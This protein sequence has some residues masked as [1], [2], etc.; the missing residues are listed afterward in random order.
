[1]RVEIVTSQMEGDAT[2]LGIQL[3]KR[4]MEGE[5]TTN[6]ALLYGGESTVRFDANRRG[7]APPPLIIPSTPILIP[8]PPSRH[9]AEGW[10]K[11]G[12]GV[13][14]LQVSPPS[15]GE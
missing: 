13:G 14:C 7:N 1:M 3:A 4:L 5:V 6:R 8:P 12:I 10:S 15:E 9:I 2:E 11:S